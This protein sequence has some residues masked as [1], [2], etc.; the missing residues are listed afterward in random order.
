MKLKEVIV[1]V[2]DTDWLDISELREYSCRLSKEFIGRAPKALI[3]GSILNYTV[4]SMVGA[5]KHNGLTIRKYVVKSKLRKINSEL[6]E[7]AAR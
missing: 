1:D 2:P 4:I 6:L 5:V 3:K 7:G